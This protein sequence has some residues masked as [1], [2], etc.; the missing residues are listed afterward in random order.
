MD[1][2]IMSHTNG[3]SLW[4]VFFDVTEFPT[5]WIALNSSQTV[6]AKLCMV[7]V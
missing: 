6:V 1:L 5:Y 7:T 3:L 4:I 2:T